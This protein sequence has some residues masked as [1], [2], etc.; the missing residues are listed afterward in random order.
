MAAQ[1][2]YKSKNITLCSDGKYRWV[3]EL[4]MYKSPA[5]IKEVWRAILIAMVIVLAFM[6]VINIMD[7]DLME[8]LEF[9]VQAAV[10]MLGVFLVLRLSC[11]C[12]HRWR[13]V[14][15]GFRDG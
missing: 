5:I 6:F 1:P 3:Y 2:V 8:T 4:D 14:L 12:V 10:V 7:S 11:F 13:K 9:L 15:R